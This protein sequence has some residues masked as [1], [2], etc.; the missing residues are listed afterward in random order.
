VT[1]ELARIDRDSWRLRVEV[2]ALEWQRSTKL[3]ADVQE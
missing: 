2:A 3:L 1:A